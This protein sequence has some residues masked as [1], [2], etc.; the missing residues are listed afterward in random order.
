MAVE[1]LHL[2]MG[3]FHVDGPVVEVHA[4]GVGDRSRALALNGSPEVELISL[5]NSFF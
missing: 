3:V 1:E 4:D 2:L 5:T